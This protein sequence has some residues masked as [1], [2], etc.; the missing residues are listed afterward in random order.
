MKASID[1]KAVSW[2]RTRGAGNRRVMAPK[3][4]DYYHRLYDQYLQAGFVPYPDQTLELRVTVSFYFADYR[5]RDTDNL[6]KA[7]QDAGQPT[8][9]MPKKQRQFFRDLWDDKQF[10][11]IHAYRVRGAGVDRISVEIEEVTGE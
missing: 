9:W 11:E 8:K 3:L 6:V 5:W 1:M 10:S 4:R 2:S 7:I